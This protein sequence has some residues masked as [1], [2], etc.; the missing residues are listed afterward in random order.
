MTVTSVNLDPNLLKAIEESLVSVEQPKPKYDMKIGML[1]FVKT[2]SSWEKWTVPSHW[3]QQIQSVP[4]TQPQPWQTTPTVYPNYPYSNPNPNTG[5]PW[6]Q[7]PWNGGGTGGGAYTPHTFPTVDPTNPYGNTGDGGRYYW[8]QTTGRNYTLSSTKVEDDTKFTTTLGTNSTKIKE[9]LTEYQTNFG[10][11]KL[12]MS[13]MSSRK[14]RRK[15]TEHLVRRQ[16]KIAGNMFPANIGTTGKIT[17]NNGPL[18]GQSI[19]TTT[20]TINSNTT[21]TTIDTEYAV[22][23]YKTIKDYFQKNVSKVE[24]KEHWTDE[25]IKKFSKS[26]LSLGYTGK[27]FHGIVVDKFVPKMK[28][29]KG[30]EIG[31]AELDMPVLYKVLFGEKNLLWVLEEDLLPMKPKECA[32]KAI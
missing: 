13:M 15:K 9:L 31:E 11:N 10:T 20:I 27:P 25:E 16:S 3:Y 28:S 18:N 21:A 30:E 4:L 14:T 17:I 24:Q 6:S 2:K 26:G 1:V 7:N 32:Q 19:S 8:D 29:E 22:Y 12:G 5:T 23:G